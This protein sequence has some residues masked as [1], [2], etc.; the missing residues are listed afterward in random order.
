MPRISALALSLV[1][2]PALTLGGLLITES[3]SANVIGSGGQN[4]NT[5]SSGLDFVTVHSSQ[6]LRPGFINVGL[7]VNDAVN[8]LPYF[9][10]TSQNRINFSN[11]LIGADLNV[12]VGLLP[13]WDAGLSL[14]SILGQGVAAD[15][16][17]HGE[18][19]KNG[20]TEVRLGTKY[21]VSGT[22]RGGVAL[23]GSMNVNLTEDDFYSGTG[24]GPT[25]NLEAVGDLT[26]RRVRLAVNLGYRFLNSGDPLPGSPIL[27]LGD[28]LI[29]S[30][31]A[32]YLLPFSDTKLIVELFGGRPMSDVS[33]TTNRASS[34]L[35]LLGGAKHDFN[36]HLAFHA[37]IGTKIIDGTSA[38]D[39]RIYT[40][41]N[42]AWGPVFNKKAAPF[43]SYRGD[44]DVHLVTQ[45]ITFDFNSDKLNEEGRELIEMIV[46]HFAKEG[47]F[48]KITVEGH[49]DSIGN[50]AYN[51]D[52]SQRRANA[53]RDHLITTF[54]YPP[55]KIVAIGYGHT[56]PIDDNG[57]FQGRQ[58]NRRV[59]FTLQK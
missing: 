36:T 24:S 32:S 43:Q 47:S 6:T 27:P 45:N 26:I 50:A 1:L 40:G 3:A 49:T 10:E 57:N 33:S 14:A 53:I 54:H 38:P 31:A 35:E 37:G 15:Q 4:F 22:D 29:A 56:R 48:Q 55:G 46:A 8:T 25:F 34:S 18:F 59:E 42:Y 20:L 2:I 11:H 51:L 21:R 44:T 19:S 5:I 52:L 41:I 28:Q 9:E 39:W 13:R 58:A 23:I 30:L 17:F 16:P 12:G 7:F